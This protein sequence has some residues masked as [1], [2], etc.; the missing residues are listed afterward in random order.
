[1]TIGHVM[2][3]GHATLLHTLGIDVVGSSYKELLRGRRK[4]LG[5]SSYIHE[6]PQDCVHSNR[7]TRLWAGLHSLWTILY[8]VL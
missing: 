3:I 5:T 2:T 6:G 8:V 7:V 1:M 4:N